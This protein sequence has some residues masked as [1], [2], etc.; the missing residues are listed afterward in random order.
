MRERILAE[1]KDGV[2]VAIEAVGVP[3]TL[4]S[5]KK[6][7]VQVVIMNIGAYGNQ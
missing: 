2:D 7:F 5:V 6:L 3:A 4:I 1:T